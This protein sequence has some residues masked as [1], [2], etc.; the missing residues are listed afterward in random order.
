MILSRFEHAVVVVPVRALVFNVDSEVIIRGN[1]MTDFLPEMS[2]ISRAAG[3]AILK[4]YEEGDFSIQ[5]KADDSPLT[6]ADLAAHEIIVA[7]LNALAPEIPVLSEES[8][9]IDYETRSQW[10][11]YFLVDPLD[12]TKEFIN[13]NGEFTV[14][15]ALIDDGV[16]ILGVVYV[17]VKDVLY[18]A[19]QLG[20]KLAFRIENNERK[21]IKTRVLDQDQPLTLVAS[22]RHGGDA[23]ASLLQRLES[24][25][26]AIDTANMGSSLKLCLVAEGQADI[27]PRLAPTSEWDTAAAQAIVEAAGGLVLDI[28]FE[29]LRYNTKASLLNPNFLVIG[30]E[31]F[32]WRQ[33]LID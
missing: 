7:G 4:V 11:R 8:D 10:R 22:R 13:R 28:N 27:Y 30:D 5:I 32:D 19:S 9:A 20:E 2:K 15:I 21:P 23:L 25:F 24:S 33:V 14:N 6:R 29:P 18:A 17:P 16:P 31:T 3:A 1:Q 26:P 12:G